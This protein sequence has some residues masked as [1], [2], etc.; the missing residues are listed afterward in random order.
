MFEISPDKKIRSWLCSQFCHR[1]W[2][3]QLTLLAHLILYLKIG[4]IIA[5]H[6]SFRSFVQIS[7]QKV[8]G[9]T[10]CDVS[11]VR[12]YW[13]YI[14]LSEFIGF[15]TEFTTMPHSNL[16]NSFS[17]DSF[18]YWPLLALFKLCDLD[19]P[20]RKNSN[21]ISDILSV[22]VLA[23]A[24]SILCL[25]SCS[26]EMRCLRRCAVIQKSMLSFSMLLYSFW[27]TQK[28]QGGGL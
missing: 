15:P 18:S 2:P 13:C 1:P 14:W 19:G 22:S 28:K 9:S 17:Q 3:V 23:S 25:F 24:F 27:L 5:A 21:L 26:L 6:L 10:K 16:L 8:L 7:R 12:D 4:V 11:V 20:Q